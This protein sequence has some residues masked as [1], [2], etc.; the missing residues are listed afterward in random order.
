MARCFRS[1]L[2]QFMQLLVYRIPE[3]P[4]SACRRN[5]ISLTEIPVASDVA[6]SPDGKFLAIDTTVKPIESVEKTRKLR[7]FSIEYLLKQMH[8]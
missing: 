8:E 1:K 2:K 5:F 4:S 3:G 6:I 7:L